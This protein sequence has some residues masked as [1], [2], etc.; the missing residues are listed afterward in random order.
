VVSAA[1]QYAPLGSRISFRAMGATTAAVKRQ[2]CCEQHQLH[3]NLGFRGRQSRRVVAGANDRMLEK[4][5][6]VG[7]TGIEPVLSSGSGKQEDS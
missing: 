7:G 3:I 4:L 6:L 1:N 2:R 5:G